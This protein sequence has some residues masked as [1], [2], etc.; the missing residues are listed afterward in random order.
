[1][2]I[3]RRHPGRLLDKLHLRGSGIE[4]G[5]ERGMLTRKVTI[6]NINASQRDTFGARSP[7]ASTIAPPRIGSQMVALIIGQSAVHDSIV[8]K[9]CFR[10]AAVFDRISHAVRTRPTGRAVRR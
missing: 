7:L 2:D 4:P 9:F 1:M 8:S 3:K 5:I 6:A 10:W